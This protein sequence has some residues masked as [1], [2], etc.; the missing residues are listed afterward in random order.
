MG[1]RGKSTLM[2]G[3]GIARALR[4]PGNE[5]LVDSDQF[6]LL[7]K[8]FSRFLVCQINIHIAIFIAVHEPTKFFKRG[9][10]QIAVTTGAH[11]TNC[12]KQWTNC[13]P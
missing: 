4:R 2:T 9:I 8:Y 1:L 5:T 13:M 12:I 10:G 6:L 3:S 7:A 11:W